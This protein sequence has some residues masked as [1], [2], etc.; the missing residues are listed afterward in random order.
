MLVDVLLSRIAAVMILSA[1][2][3]HHEN[4]LFGF[5]NRQRVLFPQ[6]IAIGATKGEEKSSFHF[7]IEQVEFN[8]PLVMEP[9]NLS[10]YTLE[11]LIP[12]SENNS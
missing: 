3:L 8:K 2:S 10:H 11:T 12:Y 7:T 6:K 5:Q 4:R 1:D 9:T